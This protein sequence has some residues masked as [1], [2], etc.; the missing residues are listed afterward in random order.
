[1]PNTNDERFNQLTA[2]VEETTTNVDKLA[3]TVNQLA[4]EAKED[5]LRIDQL[6]AEAKE[7]R[8]IMRKMLAQLVTVG[9]E[10]KQILEYLF[11]QQRG[12]G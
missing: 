11:S 1:M 3:A 9:D 7:D 10:N 4:T 6:F 5:R 8:A 2:R 12:N